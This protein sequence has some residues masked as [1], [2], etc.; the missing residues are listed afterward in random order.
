M[1]AI[2]AIQFVVHQGFN[3]LYYAYLKALGIYHSYY[4]IN[5]SILKSALQKEM[6]LCH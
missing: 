5:G 1:L 3:E 4:V 2:K 6:P